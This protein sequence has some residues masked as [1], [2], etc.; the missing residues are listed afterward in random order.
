MFI[1]YIFF[2]FFNFKI[3]FEFF[4]FVFTL[5][6][7]T[8]SAITL[9]EYSEKSFVLRGDNTRDYKD[10]LKSLG[11]KWNLNLKG[12]GGWIF[13]NSKKSKVSAFLDSLSDQPKPTPKIKKEPIET[14]LQDDDYKPLNKRLLNSKPIPLKSK[15]LIIDDV[16][17]SD[18]ANEIPIVQKRLLKPKTDDKKPLCTP[19]KSLLKPKIDT[20]IDVES[21][22]P[23]PVINRL[24]NK[25]ST[26]SLE[27]SFKNVSI[28]S[29]TPQQAQAPD[30]KG[31]IYI[32]DYSEKCFVVH[33]DTKEIKDNLKNM[34]G[35]WNANLRDNIKGWIFHMSKKKEVQDFINL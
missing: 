5:L 20:T 4:S 7:T 31:N 18:D 6:L 19:I 14:H 27:S 2:T 23:E 16:Y 28:S 10:T 3:K 26:A 34:G 29:D 21:N 8:M 24:L 12:G 1:F 32:M 22:T 13:G 30:T 33:G 25:S 11:G 35:R 9:Q 15:P 17:D